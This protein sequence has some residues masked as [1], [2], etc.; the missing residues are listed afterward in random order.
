MFV[1]DVIRLSILL[2][3]AYFVSILYKEYIP[4]ENQLA[5][6]TMKLMSNGEAIVISYF[7]LTIIFIFLKNIIKRFGLTIFKKYK[8]KYKIWQLIILI[9]FTL[10]LLLYLITQFKYYLILPF[11][12]FIL[13]EYV[14]KIK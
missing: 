6:W 9:V 7:F 4:I 2:T 12:T 8:H 1:L 10:I 5:D 14:I 13:I 3:I 11:L